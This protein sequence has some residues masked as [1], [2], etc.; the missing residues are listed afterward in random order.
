MERY[1]HRIRINCGLWD[2]FKDFK[3]HYRL[4]HPEIDRSAYVN[5]CYDINKAISEKIIKESFV[6]KMPFQLGSLSI[7]KSKFKVNIKNGKLEKN[8]LI[9]DWERTWALWHKDYPGLSRKEI[10][11]IPNKICIYNMNEHSN[12]FVMR[13]HWDRS[14]CHVSNQTVYYFKPTKQN[15]LSLAAWIKSDERENDYYLINRNGKRN[16][17][18]VI[19]ESHELYRQEGIQKVG[20]D[21]N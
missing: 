14:T 1:K 3:K 11:D 12:G 16:V 20:T 5:I 7:T 18:R 6:F 9:P 8:K 13:W 10:Y 19:K 17:R 2:A 4:I 15:R 21:R